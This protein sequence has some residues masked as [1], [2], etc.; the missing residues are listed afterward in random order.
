MTVWRISVNTE[1]SVWTLSMAIPASAKRASGE[2]CGKKSDTAGPDWEGLQMALH[3]QR[4]DC[5]DLLRASVC[6]CVR[7]RCST[8]WLIIAET[9]GRRETNSSQG[10]E[11]GKERKS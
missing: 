9:V 3:N 1:Q 11:R 7:C 5:F 4:L 10:T 2:N 6:L 8:M